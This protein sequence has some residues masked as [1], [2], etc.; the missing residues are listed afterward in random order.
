MDKDKKYA[1]REVFL[2]LQGEGVHAGRR[3]VF[4]R[5]TG[6]NMWNGHAYDR[7]KG[8][9]ACAQWCDTDFV[10]GT[11]MTK[12][13]IAFKLNELWPRSLSI[14]RRVVMTGGEPLLQ[15]D[16]ELMVFLIKQGWSIDIETNG[17]VEL[18]MGWCSQLSASVH[19]CVSPKLLADG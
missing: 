3:S 11:K 16:D 6:C 13:Q 8:M 1:V 12:E 17:T 9:G 4:L 18:P 19:V 7:N 15:L 14:V 2:T 10:G 5:F